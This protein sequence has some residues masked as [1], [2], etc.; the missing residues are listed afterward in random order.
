[1]ISSFMVSSRAALPRV[2]S[3]LLRN[4]I[5]QHST[6]APQFQPQVERKTNGRDD[7]HDALHLHTWDASALGGRQRRTHGLDGR[8]TPQD[9]RGVI[10]GRT[11][12][13]RRSPACRPHAHHELVRHC[14]VE[15]FGS[16]ASALQ[17][18]F[19]RADVDFVR[20]SPQEA[21]QQ[22][23]V[24]LLLSHGKTRG[25]AEATRHDQRGLGLSGVQVAL[26]DVTDLGGAVVHGDWIE[27]FGPNVLIDDAAAAA[28]TIAY[29]LLTGL[30]RR[31]DRHY[32][33]GEG[34]ADG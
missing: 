4:L 31:Y 14:A 24:R 25:R 19:Q 7:V 6:D 11:P 5:L 3:W 32:V 29:E 1:M 22:R 15:Y 17:A 16:D 27:L 9:D 2:C 26:F 12:R 18:G 33:G 21:A 13:E 8:V 23:H 34:L 10:S 20:R 28:G 30:G